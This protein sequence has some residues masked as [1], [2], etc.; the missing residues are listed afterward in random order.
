MK[1]ERPPRYGGIDSFNARQAA[2]KNSL[3]VAQVLRDLTQTHERLMAFLKLVPEVYFATETR[4]RRRL[5]L[6]T[7]SHYREH[8]AS[9]LAWRKARGL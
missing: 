5:R 6:D 2:G 9:I 8:T 7:Y 3:T 1:D 4:W